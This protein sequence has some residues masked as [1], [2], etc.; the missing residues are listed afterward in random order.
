MIFFL[1]ALVFVLIF[2]G[3][4]L[5]AFRNFFL[6]FMPAEGYWTICVAVFAATSMAFISPF[7]AVYAAGL[8]LAALWAS[9]RLKNRPEW[10]A[11]I[12]LAMAIAM[13]PIKLSLGG[14]GEINR[15]L[16]LTPPRILALTLLLP[17]FLR[18]VG[19][20]QP[21]GHAKY[22]QTLDIMV[23]VY[24]AYRFG[25]LLGSARFSVQ[26][27]AMTEWILD[28]G[29]FYYALTRGLTQRSHV[30]IVLGAALISLT[31]AAAVGV[32]ESINKWTFYGSLQY[33]YPGSRWQLTMLTMRGDMLRVQAMTTGPLELA[34]VLTIGI[35]LWACVRPHGEHRRL[36]IGL[37]ALL[38]V[39]LLATLSRGQL[40][41]LATFAGSMRLL[42]RASRASYLATLLGLMA[43][44]AVVKATGGDDLI[45]AALG[46]LFGKGED[47]G[48]IE[49]RRELLN[50]SLALIKQSPWT[51]VP[52]YMA[53][54]EAL[55]QGEGIVD[56]VNSYIGLM[57]D[58]GVIG[59]VLYMFPFFWTINLLLKNLPTLKDGRRRV[60]GAFVPTMLSITIAALVTIFTTSTS[61]QI[62]RFLLLLLVLPSVWLALP[63]TEQQPQ[64][65]TGLP[66]NE[67]SP[68][69][70]HSDFSDTLVLASR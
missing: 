35:G 28:V 36:T 66:E 67:S 6:S 62:L 61:D 9:S 40:I 31:M 10:I 1:K 30:Q 25:I 32:G 70:E 43:A 52:D 69:P 63:R 68:P 47:L 34:T 8:V 22:I 57:L 50:T 23:F 39:G 29:L 3:A 14:V 60:M 5:Y 64:G 17:L 12:Y 16:D 51:G 7:Q 4:A 49:Y 33:L 41:G 38:L 2:S 45:M 48:T 24:Y 19:K 46:N 53:Q 56:I 58:S 26:G 20:P 44:L 21:E 13:P 65:A 11:A 59:L 42:R 15:L 54:M 55:R 27:R 37:G 18:R